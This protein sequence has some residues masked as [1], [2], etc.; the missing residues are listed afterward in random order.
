MERQKQYQEKEKQLHL[1]RKQ[2]E[3]ERWWSGAEFFKPK[4]STEL[5]QDLDDINLIVNPIDKLRA[6]Y[7][8]D[9]SRQLV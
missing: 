9:Y 8:F 3:I 4:S 5:E 6:R 7:N 2:E 1:K